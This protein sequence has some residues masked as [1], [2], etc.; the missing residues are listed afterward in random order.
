MTDRAKSSHSNITLE[1]HL[2]RSTLHQMGIDAEKS[3]ALP[4]SRMG[5]S[6]LRARLQ[7]CIFKNRPLVVAAVGNSMTD[8]AMNCMAR[9][10]F[11]CARNT[12]DVLAT[13]HLRWGAGLQQILQR[14]LP[15]RVDV[16]VRASGGAGSIF[17]STRFRDF[18]RADDDVVIAD[19]SISDAL[20]L[21]RDGSDFE[22]GEELFVRQLRALRPHPPSFIHMESYPSFETAPMPCANRTAPAPRAVCEYYGT[23]LV[24]FMLAVCSVGDALSHSPTPAL[25]H[26]RAACTTDGSEASCKPVKTGGCG[27]CAVHPGP[28]A[29][30]IYALLLAHYLLDQ[31]AVACSVPHE[32]LQAASEDADPSLL[33]QGR[34]QTFQ[35]C[36]RPMMTVGPLASTCG[37]PTV[38]HGWSCYAD[39]PGKPGWIAL[40]N[41]THKLAFRM[42]M[43]RNGSIV[44]GYLRSYQGM[45]NASVALAG[46]KGAE[47]VLDGSWTSRSS[48]V[49]FRVIPVALLAGPNVSG[50]K[51]ASLGPFRLH[52]ASIRDV[53]ITT[54][55]SAHA[56]GELATAKFK[57]VS[58]VSC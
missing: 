42:P 27:A 11:P 34:L 50:L 33:P 18:V 21:G 8:G 41:A 13:Q 2:A 40:A 23:P 29:H 56:Q 3:L 4:G 47:V 31:A 43:S 6:N 39:R 25:R 36:T 30:H 48:Q 49:V 10:P 38:S 45:A 20:S 28:T 22:A 37:T 53:V 32:E 24:S 9:H 44:V 15:C 55:P 16:P 1:L 35:G 17:F 57:V 26:W 14:A 54:R 51:I 58:V 19:W 7:R 5:E 52:R 46:A 12:A